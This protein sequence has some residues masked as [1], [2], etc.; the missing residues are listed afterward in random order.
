MAA[1]L[2]S[3]RHPLMFRLGAFGMVLTSFLAGWLLGG[4]LALGFVFAST[5]F[6]L[7]WLEIL[8]RVRRLRMPIDRQLELTPPP[9][10]SVFPTFSE[11]T[12]EMESHAFVHVEDVGWSHDETRQFIRIFQQPESR[13]LGAICLIEQQEF[14]FYY[15]SLTSRTADGRTFLT[16]N[17]P[18][19]YGLRIPPDVQLNR[20]A[21]DG[22]I[23][24]LASAHA[25]FLSRCEIDTAALREPSSATARVEMQA[26]L[27]HQL[28]H[29]LACG[30]LERDGPDLIRY[31]MRGM[32]FLWF[33]FLR[34]FVRIS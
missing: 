6:L 23:G 29:N 7:P 5:W 1:A 12:E 20:V 14:A 15:L 2:R 26:E 31:S 24:E 3:F 22:T 10:R 19:A 9:A 25:A 18:F 4:S 21:G 30:L 27:R 34:D 13:T 28:D 16:W 8:T 33:Q 32:F 17:Y 11:L